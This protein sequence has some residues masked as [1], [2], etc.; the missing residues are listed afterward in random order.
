[1]AISIDD[2][3]TLN[4][5]QKSVSFVMANSS[6]GEKNGRFVLSFNVSDCGEVN[7]FL[8]YHM[9]DLVAPPKEGSTEMLP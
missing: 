7:C 1:M 2:C 3:E 6:P 4:K 5:V 8:P 9:E